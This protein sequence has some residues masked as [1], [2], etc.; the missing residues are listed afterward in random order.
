MRVLLDY[1]AHE[2]SVDENISYQNSTGVV[3]DML[4]LAVEP[5]LLSGCF[6]LATLSGQNVS[7][8]SLDGN[9]LEVWLDPPLAA[10]EFVNLN[11]RYDLSLPPADHFHLFGYKTDQINLVDWYPFVVPYSAGWVLHPPGEVGEHL[12]YDAADFDVTITPTGSTTDLIIAASG[13]LTGGNFRLEGARSFAVSISDEFEQSSRLVDNVTVTSYYFPDE[14]VQGVRLLDE[15][16]L[17]LTTY[18]EHFG[19]YPY[20]V[21]NIVEADFYDGMEYT[22]LFFL[23]RDFY[24]ADD[25]TKLNYLI[26]LAVHETAHQWWFG[27]VGNDQ[28]LEPWLDEALSTYSEYLFYEQN[29][30][31]VSEAWWQFRVNAFSPTGYVDSTIYAS[32]DFQT[33]AN[34]VYLRGA[35]FLSD[36]RARIGD[37][38]F[39]ALLNDY[40]AQMSGKIAT[41]GDFFLILD[42]HSAANNTDLVNEY[43]SP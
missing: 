12:V 5:N 13:S 42:Y 21:L 4:V 18:Q 3:L 34:A 26:D 8:Y 33:Y 19:S 36:L 7:G 11:I 6:S 38:A 20:P 22:G 16:S 1:A 25:G 23:G 41:R 40:A 15:V 10:N 30:P 17:A 37:E 28:A 9:R 2:L 24:L 29:Y 39:F 32:N 27:L 31:A 43:F 35:Q 14:E